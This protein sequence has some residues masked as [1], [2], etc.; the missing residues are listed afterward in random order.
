MKFHEL[1]N[2]H[3]FLEVIAAEMEGKESFIYCYP[4]SKRQIIVSKKR[5]NWYVKKNVFLHENSGEKK[6]VKISQK[7]LQYAGRYAAKND[8]LIASVLEM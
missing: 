5:E 3:L 7:S 8:L 2:L 1:G 6:E 4:N